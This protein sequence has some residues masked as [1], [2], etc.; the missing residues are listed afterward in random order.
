MDAISLNLQR[1]VRRTGRHLELDAQGK[2]L[3]GRSGR[4]RHVCPS[5]DLLFASLAARYGERC[6]AVVLT[7]TGRD[8]AEGVCAV[9]ARGGFVIAQDAADEAPLVV[10]I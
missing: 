4:V 8:G 2:L 10:K 5:A 9:R 3:V 6:C 7:G 1:E